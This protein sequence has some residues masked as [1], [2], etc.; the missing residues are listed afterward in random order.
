[1]PVYWSAAY[2]V[3]RFLLLAALIGGTV[4][5]VAADTAVAVKQTDASIVLDGRLDEPAWR[6]APVMTLVQQSPRPAEPTNYVTTVRV[7]L[8]RDRIYFG[9]LCVDPKPGRIAIHTMSRDDPMEGDDTVAIALDTY[10]DKKTGYWFRINAAGARADG[11]IADP[12]HVSYDWD[13]IWDARTARTEEGWSAE[14]VI[15]SRTLSFTPTLEQWG[16]NLERSIPR[17]RTVMRWASPTLDAFFYDLSRAGA[18][19]GV[20]ALR[21]GLGIEFSPYTIGRTK[22]FFGPS[23]R[24][25]QGAVG[26]D[27]TWKITPQF[28]SVFTANTDFAESEVDAR[29]INLTRF[30][31]FFP[32]KRAFFLEGANQFEFGLGLG[33]RF[34]PFFSRRIGLLDGEPIPI[35]AG[36]KLNGRIGRWNVGLLD[37]QTRE[38]RTSRGVVPAVNLL[39]GRVSYD[40]T[41]K[42][43][44]G[45]IFT[46]GDPEGLGRNSLFGI[47]AV[48]RT[49]TFLGRKNF[50]VGG[51][52]VMTT[53]DR[54]PGPRTGW[55][56]KVDYPNDFLDCAATVSD[57]GVALNPALGFLPRRGIRQTDL[58]CT[59]K[60]RPSKDGLFRAIRQQFFENEFTLVRNH[61]GFTESWSYFMAPLNFRL[62]SGDRAEFNWYPQYEFLATPFEVARG[63]VI[64]PGSYRFTRWRIEAQTSTH[65]AIQAGSTTWFGGFYNGSLTQWENYVK[66]T[67]PEG[68]LQFGVSTESDF[69]RLRQGNFVQRLWQLQSAFAWNQNVVL[70]SFIQYDTES[71]NLGANTR[72]RWTLK[73]GNDLFIIWNRAWERLILNPRELT[74]IPDT[75]LLA[76]KLRWT[77]R[78]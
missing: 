12:E 16:L 19:S 67:S 55:G 30:P 71:Q 56:A 42:L 38:T 58:S 20:G 17:D 33:E 47:D 49:S 68:R 75:E 23:P 76:V 7:L 8:S 78:M 15:P 26:G 37:V 57:F 50:L 41:S 34:I 62:E 53:G 59:L 27:F 52:T 29:Q 4:A 25:W 11:M 32:E 36:A 39:A 5:A 31:L 14:I 21:Q 2:H 72:L 70:S 60:P 35:N 48:W 9:F 40:V 69:G 45:T 77:F 6:D 3:P 73:P 51:W 61:K 66:W 1:M 22:D 10:G 43:R 13:G 24:A 18:M 54:Q 28:V 46:N 74:F 64:P 63:V 65:R 44:I